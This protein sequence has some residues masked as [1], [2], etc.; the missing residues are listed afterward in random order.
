[1]RIRLRSWETGW[2]WLSKSEMEPPPNL[3]G[4]FDATHAPRRIVG[5]GG[6]SGAVAAFKP[7]LGSLEPDTGM[8]FVFIPHLHPTHRGV[9][10]ELQSWTPMPV[11]TAEDG[12]EPAANAVYVIEPNCDLF[13]K[14]GMFR[15]VS[16][17]TF[18]SRH[19]QVDFFLKSLAMELGSAAIAVILSGG[20]GDGTEGC[21]LVKARGGITFAQDSSAKVDSMPFQAISMGCVDF[22]LS[23]LQIATEISALGRRDTRTASG[24][25]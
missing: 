9:M 21:A 10:K 15:S 2:V 20:D 12:M 16:P 11:F 17:R 7:L 3:S 14:R 4:I 19:H 5:I 25:G 22:V 23:P 1:M 6:S 8:A 18:A 24:T 13:L